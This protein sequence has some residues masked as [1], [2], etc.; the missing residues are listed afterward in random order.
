MLDVEYG[1]YLAIV[2]QILDQLQLLDVASLLLVNFIENLGDQL[3][4][5]VPLWLI[6]FLG[7]CLWTLRSLSLLLILSKFLKFADVLRFCNLFWWLWLFWFVN[8]WIVRWLDRSYGS[9]LLLNFLVDCLLNFFFL[10][11][12]CLP[13]IVS[14]L[15]SRP[16]VMDCWLSLLLIILW[17]QPHFVHHTII[18]FGVAIFRSVICCPELVVPLSGSCQH[19]LNI[20]KIWFIQGGMIV[21]SNL[22]PC[23]LEM[24]VKLVLTIHYNDCTC[25]RATLHLIPISNTG[26]LRRSNHQQTEGLGSIQEGE[27]WREVVWNSRDRHRLNSA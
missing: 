9:L 2:S 1:D 16:E 3:S 24:N 25:L 12:E 7:F 21:L 19:W 26:G 22:C 14:I 10:F 6:L 17:F 8:P 11:F 18:L 20:F 15:F 5:V 23:W 13:H 4:L 27:S